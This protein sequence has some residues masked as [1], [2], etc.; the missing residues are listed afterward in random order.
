[1][2]KIDGYGRK[3]VKTGTACLVLF[4]A[5]VAL[6]FAFL[7]LNSIFSYSNFDIE[8]SDLIYGELTFD[9]YEKLYRYKGGDQYEIYLEEFEAPFS[10]NPILNKK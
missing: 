10:I 9:R 1:M 6:L 3:G 4:I 7:F 5:S 8:Y 2:K